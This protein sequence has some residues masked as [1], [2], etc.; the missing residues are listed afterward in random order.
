MVLTRSMATINNAQGDELSTTTF[1]R[2]VQTLAAI[3]ECLTKQNHDLEEQACQRNAALNTQEEDQEGTNAE[4]RNQE[5]PKGSNAPSRQERLDTSRSSV[6][7]TA[8][9]HIVAEM[10][11]MKEWMNFM[12]NAFRD[13]CLATLMTWF[14]KLIHHSLRPSLHSPYHRSFVCCKWKVMTNPRTP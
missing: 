6:T 14:I 8:P 4:R 12:M 7:D 9:P 2:Q 10:Q 13:R 11:M 3:V 1:E 5:R